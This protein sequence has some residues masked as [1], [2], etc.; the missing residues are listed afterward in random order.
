MRYNPS[1]GCQYWYW[2]ARTGIGM[3]ILVLAFLHI[4]PVPVLACLSQFWHARTGIGIYHICPV[5]V[6]TYA[7]TGTGTTVIH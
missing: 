5:P 4:C 7:K 1:N 2:H 3:P 6:L